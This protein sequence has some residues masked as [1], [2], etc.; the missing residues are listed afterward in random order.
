MGKIE[1]FNRCIYCF[2]EREVNR[3]SC[4]VCG[5][6]NGICNL[7][8]W[9]L[10][11]GS[12]LKGFYMVGKAITE[13]EDELIYLGWDMRRNCL[14]EIAEYFPKENVTRD[15]TVSDRVCCIPG[16]EIAFEKG[17]QKFF[18]KARLYYKC[19][20]RLQEIDMDF[21]VRNETCYYVRE[22]EQRKGKDD[23]K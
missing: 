19:V 5:Y 8:L 21:F 10:S 9:W 6:E 16:H 14:I 20:T 4:P 22:R 1:E 2:A 23:E 3:G 18:E 15:I 11:P 7:P 13:K 17:K 12:I